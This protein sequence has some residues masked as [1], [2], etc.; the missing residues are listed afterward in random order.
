M[1]IIKGK[2]IKNQ[3]ISK[4]K[5]DFNLSFTYTQ[6]FPLTTW[7][8]THLLNKHVNVIIYDINNKTIEGEINYINNMQLQIIFNN[9]VE[10]IA[11]I[12]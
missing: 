9:P 5:L 7:N 1:S 3:S 4:D 11:I 8:I 10:G 2:Q 12:S 6:P